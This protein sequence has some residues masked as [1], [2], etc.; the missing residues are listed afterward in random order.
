[1]LKVFKLILFINFKGKVNVALVTYSFHYL[2][3][4]L[5]KSIDWFLYD[6]GSVMSELK[7]I[8]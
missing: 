4:L 8:H 3:Y 1:M 7:N 5:E 6:N 2:A